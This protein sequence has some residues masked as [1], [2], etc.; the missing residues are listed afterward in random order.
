MTKGSTY[1]QNV[2]FLED[3]PDLDEM[4]MGGGGP[5]MRTRNFQRESKY[6][7]AGILPE[8][9]AN[10]Y[11]KFIRH[12]DGAPMQESGMYVQR[13]GDNIAAPQMQEHFNQQPHHNHHS[14]H[15]N[16]PH[17]NQEQYITKE[18]IIDEGFNQKPSNVKKTYSLSEDGPSCI[19]VANHILECPICSKFY[20]NDKTLYLLIIAI[21]SI[22]CVLLLKRI[23]DM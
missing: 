9:E 7:G 11:E 10:K 20:N 17:F 4:E 22:V 14:N 23:I 8:S 15:N 5:N 13:G 1:K 6:P 16:Q 19:D 18:N 2:T 21:L 3:L 12:H